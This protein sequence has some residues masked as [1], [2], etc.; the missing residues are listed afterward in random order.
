METATEMRRR[1]EEVLDAEFPLVSGYIRND[2]L[3]DLPFLAGMQEAQYVFA[4]HLLTPDVRL[5]IWT[6]IMRTEINNR[7][8]A[9]VVI[10]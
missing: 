1:T 10:N 8:R 3:G 2:V 7:V 4:K 6:D 9:A 5:R